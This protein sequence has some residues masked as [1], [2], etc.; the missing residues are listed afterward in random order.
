MQINFI[1]SR[2]III[3]KSDLHNSVA[4]SGNFNRD[5]DYPNETSSISICCAHCD[6]SFLFSKERWL[7][8]CPHCGKLSSINPKPSRV[9]GLIFLAITLFFLLILVA[10]I[11]GTFNKIE[12]GSYGFVVLNVFLGIAF[13]YSLYRTIFYLRLKISRN[14]QSTVFT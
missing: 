4:S 2:R 13:F 5:Q 14:T 6:Y 10:T 12:L 1:N 11:L 3:V 7:A 9:R 8:R